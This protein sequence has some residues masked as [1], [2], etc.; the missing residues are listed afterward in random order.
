MLHKEIFQKIKDSN[1]CGRGGAGFPVWR[2]WSFV[3]E[4]S[5]NKKSEKVYVICNGSEGE[6]GVK[7]DEYI[8]ENYPER[9]I[10]GMRTAM[11]FLKYHNSSNRPSVRGYIYLNNRFYRKFSQSLRS[12]IHNDEIEIF[13]KPKKAGYIGGEETSVINTIE[14]KRIEPRLR[15]PFPVENGL[16][17]SPTLVNNVETFYDVSL[18]A[19]N[20]YEQKRF[21]T[22][23]GDVIHKGVFLLDEKRTINEILFETSNHPLRNEHNRAKYDF[24]VQIGG[25]GCGEIL[26]S[27]Q[28]DN[29]V[30]GGGLITVHSLTRH[31]PIELITS[32]IKFFYSESCGQCVPCR[33]GLSRMFNILRDGD[34]KWKMF[35]EILNSLE[36]SSFCGLG[37]SVHIPIKSYV[38]NVIKKYQPQELNISENN[39]KLI[40]DAGL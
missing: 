20:E 5:K 28:L 11:N 12:I 34:I 16:W 6:P 38:E 3:A 23:G 33:E 25:D 9:V 35:F 19:H 2:K 40:V 13:L 17:G 26:N 1:L 21:Y 27:S 32:W 37:G 39:Y 10:D 31:N 29:S 7:K 4:A 18:I 30:S 22:I 8:L 14:G 36:E 24:F 15:P